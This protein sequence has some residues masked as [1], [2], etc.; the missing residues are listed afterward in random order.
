VFCIFTH[1]F[2]FLLQLL[3]SLSQ[4]ALYS[5]QWLDFFLQ[6]FLL[7]TT[8][9]ALFEVSDSHSRNYEA[10]SFLAYCAMQ[11]HRSRL[12]FQRY[13]HP[14]LSGWQRPVKDLMIEAVHSQFLFILSCSHCVVIL[15]SEKNCCVFSKIYYHIP[16][17]PYYHVAIVSLQPL[18]SLHLPYWC[19]KLL[20]IRKPS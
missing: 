5:I 1:S 17:L 15:Q 12:T 8:E 20:Q 6:N 14:P 11:S 19:Y 10:D 2:Q 3:D 9:E 16:I 18:K 13:V 7:T 4:P